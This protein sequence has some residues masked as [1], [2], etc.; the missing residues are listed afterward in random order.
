VKFNDYG[1][2]PATKVKLAILVALAD[3][4]V[5]AEDT[6]HEQLI[7]FLEP[8]S[9]SLFENWTK[10][11]KDYAYLSTTISS[12]EKD[13]EYIPTF[14]Q[15]DIPHEFYEEGTEQQA[16]A[17]YCKAF[18][19]ILNALSRVRIKKKQFEDTALLL[20]LSMRALHTMD[21]NII[22]SACIHALTKIMTTQTFM[23]L[24]WAPVSEIMIIHIL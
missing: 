11:L 20:G 12:D 15:K 23:D 10:V 9:S 14:Q 8:F 5:A 16:V 19:S 2:I 6:N 3:I 22:G 1:D 7:K 4:Y 24:V 21:V 17:I 18:P 13:V